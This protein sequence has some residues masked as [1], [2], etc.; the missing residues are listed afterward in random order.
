[1]L[2]VFLSIQPTQE[3]VRSLITQLLT[4]KYW[5]DKKDVL[6]FW[7]I[8][9]KN[10]GAFNE[11]SVEVSFSLLGRSVSGDSKRSDREHVN[12]KYLGVRSYLDM[13]NDFFTD[14]ASQN[15]MKSVSGRFNVKAASLK[16][17]QVKQWVMQMINQARHNSYSPYANGS[18]FKSSFASIAHRLSPTASFSLERSYKKN[19]AE[20]LKGRREPVTTAIETDWAHKTFGEKFA[21]MTPVQVQAPQQQPRARAP[22]NNDVQ[23]K[24]SLGEWNNE[25]P[26]HSNSVPAKRTGNSKQSRVPKKPQQQQSDEVGHK[27]G[28]GEDDDADL[29]SDIDI[30]S[31]DVPLA[32]RHVSG[33][34]ERGE[35]GG[36]AASRNGPGNRFKN[37]EAGVWEREK[38]IYDAKIVAWTKDHDG[39]MPPRMYETLWQDA[40]SEVETLKEKEGGGGRRARRKH[41]GFYMSENAALELDEDGVRMQDALHRSRK[42]K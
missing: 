35:G 30:D 7:N 1:M 12:K 9:K 39:K 19:A 24:K 3:Y 21:H 34:A 31:D 36:G 38:R 33:K 2:K 20:V 29:L 13:K 11:E 14:L 32:K 25:Q 18:A 22:S 6:P 10:P 28:R 23:R 37:R 26:E 8:F 4:L 5:E 16:L 15:S 42:D 40:C 17:T 27:R 41:P